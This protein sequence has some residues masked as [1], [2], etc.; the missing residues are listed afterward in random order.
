MQESRPL[1][2]RMPTGS[3]TA[4]VAFD[5]VALAASAGACAR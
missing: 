1:G 4:T 5:V 3:D 2:V